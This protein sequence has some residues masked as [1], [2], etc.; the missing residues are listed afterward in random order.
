MQALLEIFLRT[1]RELGI[2]TPLDFFNQAGVSADYGQKA[3]VL[4]KGQTSREG[5][6]AGG[7]PHGH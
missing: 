7:H 2:S 4:E 5:G 1:H 3:R 6:A